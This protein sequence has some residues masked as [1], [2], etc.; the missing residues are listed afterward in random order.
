[1]LAQLVEIGE[2][3]AGGRSSKPHH[4]GSNPLHTTEEYMKTLI[5]AGE[6]GLRVPE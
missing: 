1:M 6:T 4:K 2:T 5:K 3:R